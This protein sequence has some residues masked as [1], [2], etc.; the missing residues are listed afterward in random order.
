MNFTQLE[1]DDI[2]KLLHSVT[3]IA[4]VGLSPKPDHSSFRVAQHVP[5]IVD[6]CIALNLLRLWLQEGVVNEEAAQRAQ[7]AGITMVMDRCIWRDYTQ[8]CAA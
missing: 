4:I 3:T 2:C 1:T 5:G 7:A 8:L 6:R